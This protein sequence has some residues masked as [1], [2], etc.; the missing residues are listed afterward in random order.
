MNLPFDLSPMQAL[1]MGGVFLVA[2]FVRGYSGFGFSALVVSASALVT[3]PLYFVA[4]VMF[5]E[6]GMTFQQWRGVSRDVKWPVVGVLMAG[7]VVGVP[8]GLALITAVDVDT[9]RAVVAIYV[10]AM[11]AVLLRGWAIAPQGLPVTGAVGVFAGAANAVGMAGLPVASF[12][13]A[14]SMP[15]AA[16]RATL[17]AYFAILDIF[18]APIMYAHGLVTWDTIIAA[19]LSTPILILG[20]WLGGRQFLRVAPSDFRRFAIGLLAVLALIGLAKAVI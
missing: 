14:Q 12:F 4:V 16:F 18:S 15:A 19:A 7:A 3:N 5:C 6:F 8:V 2:A 9:V 10:L 13:T 17:I 11:C 20:I 1:F